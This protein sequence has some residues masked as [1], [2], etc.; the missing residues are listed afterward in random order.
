MNTLPLWHVKF[1][2]MFLCKK[3]IHSKMF[4]AKKSSGKAPRP[5]LL[6]GFVFI[7]CFLLRIAPLGIHQHFSKPPVFGEYIYTIY[8]YMYINSHIYIYIYIFFFQ[9]RGD[10]HGSFWQRPS[11]NHEDSL[12]LQVTGFTSTHEKGHS[13]TPDWHPMKEMKEHIWVLNQK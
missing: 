13:T 2:W 4:Q 6:L 11:W 8:I 7:R 5:F 3:N 9:P 10:D 1:S 12:D